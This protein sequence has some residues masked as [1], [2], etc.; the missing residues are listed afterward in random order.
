MPANHNFLIPWTRCAPQNELEELRD[1]GL[2]DPWRQVTGN[3]SYQAIFI[4][5][6]CDGFRELASVVLKLPTNPNFL[7]PSTRFELVGTARVE[8][9]RKLGIAAALRNL[10]GL[11]L[12]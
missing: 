9:F 12:R 7:N 6:F 11:T 4:G 5:K 1:L 8:G 3:G 10:E 2:R